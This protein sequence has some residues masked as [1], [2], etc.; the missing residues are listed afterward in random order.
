[1]VAPT[2]P[3]DPPSLLES[4]SR[5]PTRSARAAGVQQTLRERF[6]NIG[7]KNCFAFVDVRSAP[8]FG[9]AW[10]PIRGSHPFLLIPV[11]SRNSKGDLD[12]EID[13]S[14]KGSAILSVHIEPAKPSEHTEPQILPRYQSQ[15]II[16]SS[17]PRIEI[18]R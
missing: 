16:K 17:H 10:T 15:A 7:K 14:P 9:S 11:A 1:M 4:V 2:L 3:S 6:R 8:Y 18:R 5:Q 13:I 12:G